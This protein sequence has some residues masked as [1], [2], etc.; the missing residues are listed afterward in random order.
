MSETLRAEASGPASPGSGRPPLI[1]PPN[2]R[3][4][5]DTMVPCKVNEFP[6]ELARMV[7]TEGGDRTAFNPLYIYADVGMGKT[8]LLSAIANATAHR[9]ARFV[10]VADL[11]VEHERATRECRRA[12]L[13]EWLTS[14]DILL[15]DDI[16]LCEKNE[17]L[18]HELFAVLNHMI[19]DS[20][21]V[22]IS[23]DM[24]PTRLRGVETR[25]LS[26]LGAGVIIGMGLGNKAERME[27][28]RRQEGGTDLPAPVIEYLAEQITDSIRRLRAAVVQVVALGKS[29]GVA[30]DV[31]LARAIVPM[32]GDIR[33]P[34]TNPPPPPASDKPATRENDAMAERFKRMMQGAETPEEQALALEI[35]LGEGIRACRTQGRDP[36]RLRRLERA[37]SLLR[38]G[39]L[40]R[41]LQCLD[42]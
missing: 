35:A 28:I 8:H 37:L 19:R 2:P 39:H 25:L 41:A 22:V 6:L 7:V 29:A 40:D 36:G 15:V 5:F 3:L 21:S 30:I 38:E 12:E 27:I 17:P 32:P 1:R 18:Q 14:G 23:S 26:R 20:K 10:N 9:H 24:P 42:E 13:R 33:S 31:D 16:Q 34:S 11:E 4:T